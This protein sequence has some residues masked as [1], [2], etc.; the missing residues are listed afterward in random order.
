MKKYIQFGLFLI[1]GLLMFFHP[2]FLDFSKMPGDIGDARFIN[3]ILEHGFLFFKGDELHS[4]FWN[5]PFFFPLQ[6]V[7]AFSDVLLGGMFLYIP[8]RMFVDSPQ[9]ALQ[10]QVFLLCFLNYFSFFLFS[11]KVFKFNPL[12]SS[13]SAFLFAFGLP[14]YAQLGHLQLLTQFLSVFS[15]YFFFFSKGKIWRFILSSIFL[16]LQFYTSFYLGWFVF[17][18]A[19]LFSTVLILKDDTRKILIGF[20]KENKNGLICFCLTFLVVIYPLAIHYLQ[21]GTTFGATDEFLLQTKSFLTSYSLI[22]NVLYN[23]PPDMINC[24]A[25]AGIGYFTG[26][27]VLFGLFSMKKYKFQTGLF[28]LLA[29]LFFFVPVL[30][31]WLHIT[32]PG[33]SVIRAGGRCIFL[34]LPVFCY[35]AACFFE[36]IKSGF[37]FFILLL[38]LLIEQIPVPSLIAWN[39]NDHKTRIEKYV[40]PEKCEAFTIIT[41][42]NDSLAEIDAM[43]VGIKYKKPTTNGYSGY[44]PSNAAPVKNEECLIKSNEL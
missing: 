9:T 17:F 41:D 31:V 4:S 38:I 32:I 2:I 39:K 24:E 8:V 36:K 3:Y 13:I 5:P 11:R 30:N 14:R 7:L 43:W 1:L 19:L 6:N 15:L 26:A 16:V 40:V 33:A 34:I 20:L 25:I 27:A 21:V 12:I 29:I 22:D 42:S 10:I 28:I 37:L 18:G 23:N 44:I 35:L